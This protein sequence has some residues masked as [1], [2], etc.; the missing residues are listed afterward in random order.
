MKKGNRY[1][2]VTLEPDLEEEAAL[3]TPKQ[4]R[5][6]AKL[7]RRYA[8]QLEVS[9][10]IMEKFSEPRPKPFLRFVCAQVLA[11]N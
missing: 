7:Y 3:W 8:R 10:R 5:A 9:A 6:A 4:R 1:C 11:R 2:P